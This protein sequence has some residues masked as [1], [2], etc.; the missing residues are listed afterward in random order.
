MSQ[1]W[2][3]L[4]TRIPFIRPKCLCSGKRREN[5]RISFT[6]GTLSE[7]TYL[8]ERKNY[9]I[10]CLK[11]QFQAIGADLVGM[12]GVDSPLLREHGEEPEKLLPGAK[13]LISIGVGKFNN[14]NSYRK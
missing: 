14:A 10:C 2:N 3:F 9:A 11:K 6:S 8:K 13:S 12:A 1:F 7:I 5:K 4:P